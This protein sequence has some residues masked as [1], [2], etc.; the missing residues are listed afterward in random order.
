MI[1]LF[2]IIP[3]YNRK[4]YTKKCLLSLRNQTYKG[5]EIVVVDDGSTDGTSEMVGREFP[6]VTV[7]QGDGNLWW[8]GAINLGIRHSLE[9]SSDG[10]LVLVINNDLEVPKNYLEN[11]VSF[12]RQYKNALV[13]SVVVDINHTDQILF[14]GVN[15]NWDTAKQRLVNKNERL[16]S[17][18]KSYFVESDFLTGRGTLVPVEVFKQIGLYDDRHFQQ[19]G[20]TELP[21][22]AVK[23]GYRLLVFYGAVIFSHV[24][25]GDLINVSE[26]YRIS[27]LKRYFFDVKSNARLKYRFYFAK[28]ALGEN[29]FRFIVYLI[30]DFA[31]LS[32]S[33]VRKII[34]RRS[35]NGFR[36]EIC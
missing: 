19:C 3:V 18:H 16:S 36:C 32:Y 7:L 27:D 28:S 13:G 34:Y 10:D 33:F 31:R 12:A 1:K 5:F 26:S 11:L 22:R 14:G 2:I 21:L 23:K 17:F 9:R 15:V 6:E 35:I 20:D 29:C 25:G 24:K 4:E 8:T 30:C